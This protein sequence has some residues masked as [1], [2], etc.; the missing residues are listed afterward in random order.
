MFLFAT[1]SETIKGPSNVRKKTRKIDPFQ[2]V[3]TS[4][5]PFLVRADTP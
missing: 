5:T 3:R 2:N 4:S 1:S